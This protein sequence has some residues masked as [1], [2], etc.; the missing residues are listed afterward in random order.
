ME[1]FLVKGTVYKTTYMG[2]VWQFDDLRLVR[3]ESAGEAERKWEAW[4][5]A[6]TDEY[7]VYYRAS[8]EAIDTV[9]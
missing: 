3:A 1:L 9:E 7:S 6:K 2:D 8:G 5:E 4:W